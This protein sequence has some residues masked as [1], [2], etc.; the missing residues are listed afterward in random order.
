MRPNKA[1]LQTPHTLFGLLPCC[2]ATAAS[3]ECGAAERHVR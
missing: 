1:L 2:F 3:I